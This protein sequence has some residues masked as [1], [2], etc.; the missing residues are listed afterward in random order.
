MPKLLTSAPVL[1]VR[2]VAASA[3]YFRDCCG[4]RFDRF[5]GDPP[6]FCMVWR[7]G[8]CVMLKETR[9]TERIQPN[10]TVE[11]KLW[12]A[13]FWVDDA[14]GLHA[15]FAAAGAHIDYGPCTQPHGCREFGIQD[16]DGHDL[17]FGQ[18]LDEPGEAPAVGTVGG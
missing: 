4:F 16:L 9:H 1:L 3:A 10:W 6:A 13:Y 14:D 8:L 15:E 18:D 17:A 11:D 12:D 5:W 7:D 2:D